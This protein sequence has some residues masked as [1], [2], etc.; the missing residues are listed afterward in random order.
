MNTFLKIV[1]LDGDVQYINP[2]WI[3]SIRP[4]NRKSFG[5]SGAEIKLHDGQD[6]K[7]WFTPPGEVTDAVLGYLGLQ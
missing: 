1:D 7:S 4:V 3:V 6:T 5:D 2:R